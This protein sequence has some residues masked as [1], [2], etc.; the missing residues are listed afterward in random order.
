MRLESNGSAFCVLL[1]LRSTRCVVIVAATCSNDAV[2]AAT[3][4]SLSSNLSGDSHSS[5][6]SGSKNVGILSWTSPEASRA[7]RVMIAYVSDHSPDVSS[8]RAA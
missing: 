2:R 5:H 7:S 6:R 8:L 4:A 1:T 3:M